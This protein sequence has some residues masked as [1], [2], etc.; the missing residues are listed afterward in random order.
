M[1]RQFTQFCTLLTQKTH[2]LCYAGASIKYA[3]LCLD[4]EIPVGAPEGESGPEPVR[5][6]RVAGE[7]PEPAAALHLPR[8][9]LLLLLQGHGQ[10][11]Q[12]RG[13]ALH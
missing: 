8:L 7:R 9:R 4:S 1:L 12:A 13:R 2:I 3:K 11:A 5:R 10:R 6:V